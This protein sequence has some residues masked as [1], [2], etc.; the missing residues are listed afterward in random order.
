[1]KLQIEGRAGDGVSFV[2]CGHTM[3]AQKLELSDMP[4][5][6][7]LPTKAASSGSP[8]FRRKVTSISAHEPSSPGIYA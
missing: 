2:A 1:M 7:E 5:G 4:S 8:I 3:A 6:F